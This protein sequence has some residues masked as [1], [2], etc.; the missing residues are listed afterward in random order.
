M[1]MEEQKEIFAQTQK[2]GAVLHHHHIHIDISFIIL[3]EAQRA[4]LHYSFYLL[5]W[6]GRFGDAMMMMMICAR[7]GENQSVERCGV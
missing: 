2:T 1:K 7:N 3:C 5:T 4:I 6:L